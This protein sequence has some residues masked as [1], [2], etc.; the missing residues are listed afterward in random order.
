M[1]QINTR[2]SSVNFWRRVFIVPVAFVLAF[3]LLANAQ[4]IASDMDGSSSLNLISYS[5]PF[6]FAF[7]SPGDGFQKYQRGVSSSI[8]FAVL[9]DSLSIFPPDNLGIIK[10]GNTDIFFGVVDTEN[11]DNSGP[12]EATWVFN[13]SGASDLGLS[14]DMGAMGDFESS[15]YFIWRYS[16]DGGPLTT[17]FASS[18]D[19]DG[20]YTYTLEGGGSFTL[21]DPMLMQGEVLTNDLATFS[22]P[23]SGTGTTLELTLEAVFNGGS[24]A[25]A[26]QN[27]IVGTGFDGHHAGI[28]ERVVLHSLHFGASGSHSRISA[29]RRRPAARHREAGQAT[30]RRSVRPA[31][32]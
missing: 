2:S 10:E 12:V 28:A 27:V 3:P 16:I 22:T 7:G 31:A 4:V 24:E 18:V 13:I 30:E 14:I 32:G 26:F 23:I 25:V 9:D 5:N 17:A 11:S 15:D 20:S 21:N 8:P 1:T 19:E 29:A 6:E